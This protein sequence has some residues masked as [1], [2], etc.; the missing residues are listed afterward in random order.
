MRTPALF[1]CE[2]L[3]VTNR[4]RCQ[5]A[6]TSQRLAS[7]IGFLSPLLLAWAT[8]DGDPF[9]RSERMFLL[10]SVSVLWAFYEGWCFITGTASICAGRISTKFT[11][12]CV[13][14]SCRIFQTMLFYNVRLKV[15]YE[16]SPLG[17]C[18]CLPAGTRKKMTINNA[19][20]IIWALSCS[21][22]QCERPLAIPCCYFN[23]P[24]QNH[25]AFPR[26]FS[27]RHK[28]LW[29]KFCYW[30]QWP[31][32]QI[33]YRTLSKNLALYFWPERRRRG[34]GFYRL[35]ETAE[36]KRMPG[37]RHYT[38]SVNL[39]SVDGK[40]K[41]IPKYRW[42]DAACQNNAYRL[43]FDTEVRRGLQNVKKA[44]GMELCDTAR[45]ST[46]LRMN[47]VPKSSDIPAYWSVAHN[48]S[49]YDKTMLPAN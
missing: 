6:L 3:R 7:Q 48:S 32:R 41:R 23:L 42:M 9:P 29:I 47:S 39:R 1:S 15:K 38:K 13:P 8:V 25:D 10:C 36:L 22:R 30:F 40:K 46:P 12:L 14:I 45:W 5:D 17:S 2:R 11:P 16:M 4:R 37:T 49:V 44:Y 31:I 28:C 34:R 24:P 26:F 43:C 19:R 33:L 27:A 18:D 21:W 20:P 35:I